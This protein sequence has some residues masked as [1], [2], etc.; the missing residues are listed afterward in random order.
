MGL[1]RSEKVGCGVRM[2][3]KFDPKGE[4]F[5]KKLP[6]GQVSGFKNHY[7]TKSGQGMNFLKKEAPDPTHNF[8]TL[9]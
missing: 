6:G 8:T 9:Q 5:L 4:G 1:G 3:E 7:L 2:E